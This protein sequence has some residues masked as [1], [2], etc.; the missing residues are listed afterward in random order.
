VNQTEYTATARPYGRQRGPRIVATALALFVL[1]AI[2]KPWPDGTTGRRPT[3]PDGSATPSARAAASVSP[4]TATAS[5]GPNT[6]ACLTAD[7]PQVVTIE[8]A[9]GTEI[10][11]WIAVVDEP[12]PVALGQSRISIFSSHVVGLG[13]CAPDRGS[14]AAPPAVA[15]P[16]NASALPGPT[17]RRDPAATILVVTMLGARGASGAPVS[18]AVGP[19]LP[20]QTSG[21]DTARLYGPPVNAAASPAQAAA[22]FRPASGGPVPAEATASWPVGSWA[23]GFRYADDGPAVVRWVLIDILPGAAGSG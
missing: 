1:V 8:R 13:V 7:R 15:S 18:V 22:S 21:G 4:T 16:T 19:A 3:P 14:A 5:V 20:G 11:S 9:V 12:A 23:I 2:V 17:S 6:M 10:R